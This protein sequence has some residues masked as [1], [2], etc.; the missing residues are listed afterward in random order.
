[1]KIRKFIIT[2]HECPTNEICRIWLKSQKGDDIFDFT[3]GQF[4]ILHDLNEAGESIFSRSYSIAS[5]PYL[6]KEMIELGIKSQGKMSGKLYSAKPG[7][8]F[9]V[10]GP[11][12][13]FKLSDSKHTVLFA[14]GIG[15]T[16]IR[17][18]IFESLKNNPQK[19]LILFYSGRSLNDLIFHK[20]FKKL[21]DDNVNFKYIPIITRD[22]PKDWI[23]EAQRFDQDML[24][25]Y[26]KDLNDDMDFIMCGPME[27]MNSVKK[28][29]EA[30]GVD[31]KAKL[32]AESY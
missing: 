12:G 10:Q 9:G 7:D 19:E 3:A 22:I 28:T 29:L 16:P 23:Y 27:M 13:A 6:S 4:I 1:M 14:G 15:V 2:R 30:I 32:R 31:V 17:S 21:S 8:V 5:P 20:E 25:K 11:Y 18:M 26:V 24:K